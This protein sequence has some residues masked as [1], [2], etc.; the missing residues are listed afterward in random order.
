MWAK[1]YYTSQLGYYWDRKTICWDSSQISWDPPHSSQL[2]A[3]PNPDHPPLGICLIYQSF[4]TKKKNSVRYQ[5]EHWYLMFFENFSLKYCDR[6]SISNLESFYLVK[7]KVLCQLG[8]SFS[9]QLQTFWDFHQLWSSV[10]GFSFKDFFLKKSLCGSRRFK[11]CDFCF[12]WPSPT[13]ISCRYCFGPTRPPY[14]SKNGQNKFFST[15]WV[16]VER[17]DHSTVLPWK[18]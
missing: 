13:T 11:I 1:L 3:I 10:T 17:K 14:M 12:D 8:I 15:L 16:S 7:V 6:N 5:I 18:L 4:C 2:H 9:L